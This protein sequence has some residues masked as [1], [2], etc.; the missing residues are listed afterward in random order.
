VLLPCNVVVRADPATA[1]AVIVEAMDPHILVDV[2]GKPSLDEVAEQVGAK[3]RAAI[4]ALT[5][6]ELSSTTTS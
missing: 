5:A 1:E 3:L 6:S 4:A 2:T